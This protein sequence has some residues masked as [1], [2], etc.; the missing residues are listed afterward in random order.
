MLSGLL[1]N[2]IGIN[3]MDIIYIYIERERE[4]ILG[5]SEYGNLVP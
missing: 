2:L 4:L 1:R 5:F 3:L